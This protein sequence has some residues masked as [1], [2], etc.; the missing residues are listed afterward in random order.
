MSVSMKWGLW[1]LESIDPNSQK[2]DGF[3]KAETPMNNIRYGASLFIS[4]DLN[5]Y[6]QI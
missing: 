4:P 5:T 1:S 2:R 3:Y 6:F